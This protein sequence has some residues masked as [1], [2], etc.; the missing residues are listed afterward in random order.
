MREQARILRL[1]TMMVPYGILHFNLSDTS[2]ARGL[3]QHI[4]SRIDI[5]TAMDDALQVGLMKEN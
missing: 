1:K 3:M 2:L 4:L 5:P